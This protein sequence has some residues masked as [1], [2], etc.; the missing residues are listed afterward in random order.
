MN[1]SRRDFL[2]ASGA[3][4]ATGLLTAC[5]SGGSDGEGSSGKIFS[6]RPEWAMEADEVTGTLTV[7]TTMLQPEQDRIVEVFAEL[8]PDCT[9]QFQADSV[10]TLVTRIRSDENSDADIIAGGMFASDGDENADILQPYVSKAEEAGELIYT[11]ET[12]MKAYIDIQEMCL[13]VN[14]D[15][16]AEAGVEITGYASLLDDALD[17][18]IIVADPASSSSGYRQL[19]T[20]LAVMGD[21]FADEKAWEYVEKLVPMTFSTTSSKDVF[22]LVANGEYIVGLSYENAVLEQIENGANLEIVYMEEGNTAM[23]SGT[24]ITVNAP[25]LT[26]AQALTDF[27][28]SKEHGEWRAVNI[29][30]RSNNSLA[31][32]SNL[33]D[34]DTLGNVE[35]DLNY[36]IE[37]KQ[38]LLDRYAD[39]V[40][41]VS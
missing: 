19:Q 6:E 40:A 1:L 13:C 14:P 10:G 3:A 39:I 20:M 26:A 22:N 29:F 9:V 33:T 30:G 12:Q 24:A 21:E 16:A 15:L 32:I 28:V 2:K 25:N 36:L 35:M 37:H 23:A 4:A 27:L 31:E 7:Y 18:Q 11:D 8:Y 34:I 41:S 5:S 38:E 17:G